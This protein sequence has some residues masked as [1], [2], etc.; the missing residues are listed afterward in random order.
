MVL[1][2]IRSTIESYVNNC[3]RDEVQADFWWSEFFGWDN[4]G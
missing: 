4:V 3:M 2:E 1:T